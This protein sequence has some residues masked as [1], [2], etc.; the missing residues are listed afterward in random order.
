[1]TPIVLYLVTI[2]VYFVIYN[3]LV[4]GLNIQFGYAGLLNFTYITFVAIGAYLA[5]VTALGRA[6]GGLTQIQYI[7]GL[8]L[9]F[10]ADL[11]VGA[12]GAGALGLVIGFVAL[13][14]LRSDYTAI[15]M[16]S[17]GEI[18]FATVGN[19]T[20]LFNGQTGLLDVPQPLAGNLNLSFNN[21]QLF[22]LALSTAIM[23]V[24]WLAANRIYHSPFGRTL[25]AIRDDEDAAAG[26]GKSVFTYKMTAFVVGCVYAGIGGALTMEYLTAWSPGAWA[27]SETF[28]VWSAML[29]GGRANNWGAILGS[30]LVPILFIEATRFLPPVSGH[31][32]LIDSVRGV[33]IGLLVLGTL[34]WRPQGLLPE[35]RRFIRLS[36][37]HRE[38][39]VTNV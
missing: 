12:L 21:Y 34:W 32:V 26:F 16:V 11:V 15:V 39:A 2:A 37:G 8:G 22:F 25:R 14:R 33:V 1:M 4:L 29:V 31:P 13:R 19:Q 35:R 18:V 20:N 28:I 24:L 27:P 6:P 3:I 10:P 23:L 17:L 30:F 36:V 9:P 38:E 7:F 5:G